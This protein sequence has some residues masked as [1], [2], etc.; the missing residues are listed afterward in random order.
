MELSALATAASASSGATPPTPQPQTPLLPSPP[1]APFA[2]AGAA[3]ADA[4]DTGAA[5]ALGLPSPSHP[6]NSLRGDPPRLRAGGKMEF[7]S[8]VAQPASAATPA[9]AAVPAAAAAAAAVAAPRP[10][11]K[12]VR[13]ELVSAQQH[14][15][16]LPMRV[17]I[18]PHDTTES[19]V[20]TVKNFY[21]LYSSPT[22]SKGVSFEDEQGNT[23]I[24]R[25]ENFRADMVVY[26]RVF[27]EPAALSPAACGPLHH[28]SYHSP[29]AG[30]HAFHNGDPPAPLPA[31][32]HYGPHELHELQYQQPHQQ[33][34]QQP[35]QPHISRPGSRTSRVRS[36]S[37]NGS[38][39]GRRSASTGTNPKTRLSR[40]PN[41]ARGPG[42][43]RPARRRR[44]PDRLHQRRRRARLGL[45]QK[46][47]AAADRQ[48]RDQRREHRRGRPS[49]A[50]QV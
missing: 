18:Y 28:L 21:G 14:K 16:R 8:P 33:P 4:G 50:G 26:V 25:Y 32:L 19:I 15:A 47:G 5:S 41:K 42:V 37:P 38:G 1:R 45:G 48:H 11:P 10:D 35:Q 13:F 23:L 9:A 43:A 40:P 49:Q 24:A 36:P 2:S 20:T 3:D 22:I 7:T 34:H 30:A 31:A 27:E 46:Q 12:T 44:Q 17:Q 6:Y 29:G 39:R